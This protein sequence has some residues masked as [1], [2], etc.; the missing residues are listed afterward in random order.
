MTETIQ[1]IAVPNLDCFHCVNL[2]NN[3]VATRR[4]HCLP[5]VD[6]SHLWYL[7]P[8]GDVSSYAAVSDELHVTIRLAHLATL[9]VKAMILQQQ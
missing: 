7:K 4:L 2:Y 6:K 3:R 8:F 9:H 5:C 1:I